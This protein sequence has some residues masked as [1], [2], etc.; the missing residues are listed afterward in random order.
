[1]PGSQH[2]LPPFP[3]KTARA[4]LAGWMMIQV[5]DTAAASIALA[6]RMLPCPQDCGQML[7]PW[8]HARERTVRDASGALLRVRP[9]RALC[10]GC[11]VTHVVLDARLL[12]RHGYAAGLIG[13]AV[14]GAA[15]GSGHRSIAAE[16]AV[17]PGTVRGWIRGARRSA[18]HLRAEGI[19]TLVHH[20]Q[21]MPARWPPGELGFA[22]ECLGAA[23]MALARRYQLHHVSP[24]AVINVMTGG[25]LLSM[26]PSG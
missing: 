20:G 12:P 9:D 1:M 7:R 15:L 22:L 4:I 19:R 8:G 18:I 14:L 2:Q 23:A 26:A 21:D 5:F 3:E 16:L 13:R 25:R 6:R 11:D 10:R 17:P 24:W